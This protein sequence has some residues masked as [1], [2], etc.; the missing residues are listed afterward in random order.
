MAK[1]ETHRIELETL[2]HYRITERK[3][4]EIAGYK[5]VIPIS[6]RQLG[7]FFLFFIPCALLSYLPFMPGLKQYFVI[8]LALPILLTYGL[9][10]AKTDGKGLKGFVV[11]TVSFYWRK[12]ITKGL[13]THRMQRK[14]KPKTVVFGSPVFFR[15]SSIKEASNDEDHEAISR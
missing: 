9:Y 3:Q 15:Y 8:Y 12:W 13:R 11:S 2:D 14:G 10:E 5:L 4:Y 7:Y 6:F 1:Q